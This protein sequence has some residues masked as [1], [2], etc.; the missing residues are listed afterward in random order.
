MKEN[1]ARTATAPVRRIVVWLT[2]GSFSI[3]ALMGIIALLSGGAFGE[4]EGQVLLTTLVVGV[5]SVAML[6]YLATAGTRFQAVGVV[7]GIVVLVP[8]T[9]ALLLVWDEGSW[10]FEA[11]FKTFSTGLTVAATLAQLA[12]LL[13]V[14]GDR[15][16]LRWVLW[17]T[18]A[19]AVG[20]A[21]VTTTV[22]FTEADSDLT[23]R[24]L[25][26]MAIL[27]VLGTLTTLAHAIFGNRSPDEAGAP[28]RIPAR[29]EAPLAA[30]ATG[31]GR[32]RD[33]VVAEALDAWF[34]R[35][36]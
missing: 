32:S 11:F 33:D 36:P 18:V 6:C 16:R 34:A 27:D 14:A 28:V 2:I 19:L 25:G 5:T 13:A 31:S 3:A 1:A 20:V 9:Q 4:R 24:T 26:V 35:S 17:P 7:G 30:A 8:A 22:I 29:L 10:D 15:Q 12:L 21:G 23:L